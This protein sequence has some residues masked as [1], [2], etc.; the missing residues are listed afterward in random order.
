M[1]L[2]LL[3][4]PVSVNFVGHPDQLALAPEFH[5]YFTKE[6]ITFA[7][8]PMVGS[9]EGFSFDR[10]ADYPPGLRDILL[11]YSLPQLQDRTKFLK[12]ERAG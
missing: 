1:A 12:G 8:I 4:Y 6:G 9:F 5:E 11:K 10:I 2:K 3:G 7:L